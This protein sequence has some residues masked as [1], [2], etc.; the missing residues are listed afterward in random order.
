MYVVVL[1]R[2]CRGFRLLVLGSSD[3]CGILHGVF[4]VS[5]VPVRLG[6][7]MH[8][9]L[10]LCGVCNAVRIVCVMAPV[11]LKAVLPG[12]SCMPHE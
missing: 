11:G 6:S 12:I 3:Q 4:A 5:D 7:A 8:P 9:S 1:I 10:A 2:E